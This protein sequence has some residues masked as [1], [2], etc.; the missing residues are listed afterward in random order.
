M[1]L[2]TLFENTYAIPCEARDMWRL[3]RISAFGHVQTVSR[4]IILHNRELHSHDMSEC[5]YDVSLY[6]HLNINSVI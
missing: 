3:T 4:Q 1:N 6:Y 2:T 5:R